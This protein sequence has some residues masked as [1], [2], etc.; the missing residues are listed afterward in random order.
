MVAMGSMVLHQHPEVV[1]YHLSALVEL[2]E[3]VA[4]L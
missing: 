3:M 4:H 2:E 1:Q